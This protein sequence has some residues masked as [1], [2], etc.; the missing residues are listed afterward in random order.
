MSNR[1]VV[2]TGTDRI[3]KESQTKLLARTLWPSVRFSSPD[4]DHWS[5]QIIRAI[6]Q[7]KRFGITVEDET[8]HPTQ[9][10][11]KHPEIFQGLQSINMQARQHLIKAALATGHVIMDRY[12][13]DA[14]A[15]G[16]I[17]GCGMRYLLELER[18]LI[19]SDYVII[20]V[21][22]PFPRPGEE[23]D[24][25]ERDTAFQERVRNAYMA[26]ALQYPDTTAVVDVDRFRDEQDPLGSIQA[27]N[28]QIRAI[29]ASTLGLFPPAPT[30]GLLAEM[31]PHLSQTNSGL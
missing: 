4:Y 13:V 26:Y 9:C 3:G 21:G 29:L 24:I 16:L 1:L 20:L 8:A 5:G 25:N 22:K 6:L 10:Q 18:L 28:G 31:F 11:V 12:Q 27:V 30:T 23:P 14:L 17:D 2:L 7:E 15:Y 19:P